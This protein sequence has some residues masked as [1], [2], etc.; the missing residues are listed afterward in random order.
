[1]KIDNELEKQSVKSL[2]LSIEAKTGWGDSAKWTDEQFKQL[3]SE[4]QDAT[5]TEISISTLKIIFGHIEP[6]TSYYHPLDNTKNALAVYLG[7]VNWED[8]RL[9]FSEQFMLKE[10]EIISGPKKKF[11]IS[12]N[13]VI[14]II[15]IIATLIGV[16]SVLKKKKD[17][18]KLVSKM[19]ESNYRFEGE[20]KSGEVPHTLVVNYDITE[21]IG[22]EDSMYIDFDDKY[23]GNVIEKLD[24]TQRKITHSY[25]HADYFRVK[26]LNSKKVLKT[27][28]VQV[29]SNGWVSRIGD[30]S[31]ITGKYEYLHMNNYLDTLN[32]A[33]FVSPETAKLAGL[34]QTKGFWV[35]YT[36]IRDFGVE[37]DELL[38]ETSVKNS[39]NEGGQTCFD[40]IIT[41]ICEQGNARVHFLNEGCTRWADIEIA[42]VKM[43]GSSNDLSALGRDFSDWKKV[44]MEIAHQKLKVFFEGKEIISQKYS[45]SLGKLKGLLFIFKGCGAIDYVRLSDGEG[46]II[47][48]EEFKI[49]N[50]DEYVNS[51]NKKEKDK[52]KKKK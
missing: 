21:I 2:I 46:T 27:V 42:D 35:E 32:H 45:A 30:K 34:S 13:G 16:W 29:T 22:A 8:C 23:L 50:Y 33:L 38:L 25:L 47:Y 44:K 18:E 19:L 51:L 41:A 14:G 15:L 9:R 49:K 4:I 20:T 5:S 37:G 28:G 7:Y 12:Y 1:M 11:N 36:N 10:N 31:L 43:P 24:K 3:S 39:E 26:L 17:T 48:D 52:T 6:P 40:V